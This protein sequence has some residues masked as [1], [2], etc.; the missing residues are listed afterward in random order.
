MLWWKVNMADLI[1]FF[2]GSFGSAVM[3]KTAFMDIIDALE[4]SGMRPR[5]ISIFRGKPFK[6]VLCLGFYFSLFFS[7]YFHRELNHAMHFF[8]ATAAAG[9]CWIAN[10]YVTGEY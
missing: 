2:L 4:M 5:T 8:E 6:C 1:I 3:F 10:K 9:F 7:Y